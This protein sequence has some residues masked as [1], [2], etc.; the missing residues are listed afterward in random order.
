MA[1]DSTRVEFEEPLVVCL[2]PSLVLDLGIQNLSRV[3][4]LRYLD[5]GSCVAKLSEAQ[6]MNE[7]SYCINTTLTDL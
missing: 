4:L 5:Y 1:L 7:L 2:G 3:L 6:L